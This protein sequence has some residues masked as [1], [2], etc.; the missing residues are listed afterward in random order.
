MHDRQLQIVLR[1]GYVEIPMNG[2]FSDFDNAI[3]VRRQDVEAINS[4]IQ[5]NINPLNCFYINNNNMYIIKIL[6]VQYLSI[7]IFIN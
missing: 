3:M 7:C 1:Q 4:V 2:R 6:I 5:V